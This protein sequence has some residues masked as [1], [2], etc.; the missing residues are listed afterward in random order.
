MQQD[1]FLETFSSLQDFKRKFCGC[2]QSSAAQQGHTHPG[3]SGVV[4]VKRW[5]L[6]W[7]G[8]PSAPWYDNDNIFVGLD[9]DK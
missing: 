8:F 4:E 7:S 9:T 1:I 3:Q 2:E 5:T 6:I